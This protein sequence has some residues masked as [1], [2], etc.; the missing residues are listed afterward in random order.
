M[1]LSHPE[2]VLHLLDGPQT[3]LFGGA[4]LQIFQLL[5]GASSFR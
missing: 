4:F 5:E 3:A 1:A 2:V